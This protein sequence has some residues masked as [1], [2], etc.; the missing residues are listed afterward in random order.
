VDA[1]RS[2]GVEPFQDVGHVLSD[3]DDERIVG[4][5]VNLPQLDGR[6]ATLTPDELTEFADVLRHVLAADG[7]ARAV[8][9]ELE[10]F[11]DRLLGA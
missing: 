2:A 3:V 6:V 8:L 9:K 4:L 11:R 1:A 7:D 5:D 10:R